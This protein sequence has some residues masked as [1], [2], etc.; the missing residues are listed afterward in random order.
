MLRK[1]TIKNPGC[2][3]CR[4]FLPIFEYENKNTLEA[5]IIKARRVYQRQVSEK[6]K[7]KWSDCDYA[8]EKN[9]SRLCSDFTVKSWW[10]LIILKL[11]LKMKHA[12][13]QLPP[14]FKREIW[15]ND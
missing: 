2:Q 6:R 14:T 11:I 13:V 15:W 5:C 9:K 10:R 12:E 7:W 3:F 1:L 8:Q 4:Y